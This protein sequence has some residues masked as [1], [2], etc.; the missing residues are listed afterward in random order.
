VSSLWGLRKK[1]AAIDLTND[2]TKL[3]TIVTSTVANLLVVNA[4]DLSRA[5]QLTSGEPSLFQVREL[6]DRRLLA[7]GSGAWAMND[8]ASHRT[9]FGQVEDPRAIET[10]G[11]SVL[12]RTADTPRTGWFGRDGYSRRRTVH[13]GCH[14]V[15]WE[16]IERVAPAI[17][18]FVEVLHEV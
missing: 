6:P 16:E 3:A 14:V 8:D 11:S 2:G 15:S 7:L 5:T 12:Q 1:A 18:A 10:C 17:E 9:R 13:A 4:D